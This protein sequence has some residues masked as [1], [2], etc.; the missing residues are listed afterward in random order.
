MARYRQA[1]RGFSKL[2]FA[3]LG[4]LPVG[5]GAGEGIDPVVLGV[6]AVTLDPMPVDSVPRRGR[7]Q[8]LPQ[9]GVLDRLLVRGAPAVALP[10]VDPAGDAIAD[11][12]AVGM[13]FYATGLGERFETTM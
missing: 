12:D 3:N 1:R 9:L 6:A 5:L 10:I 11:V 2:T 8:L 7:D 13:Q 4:S